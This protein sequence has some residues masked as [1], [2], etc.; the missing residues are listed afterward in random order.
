M[1]LFSLCDTICFIFSL[2]CVVLSVSF[3]DALAEIVSNIVSFIPLWLYLAFVR[4][5]KKKVEE[6]YLSVSSYDLQLHFYRETEICFYLNIH[7]K[8]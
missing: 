4:L 6:N 1:K 7:S 2:M 8:I 5:K 3:S